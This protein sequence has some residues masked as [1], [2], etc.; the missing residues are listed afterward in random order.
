MN[1][2]NKGLNSEIEP[3]S[4]EQDSF[5]C[6]REIEGESKCKTQ[7]EHCIDYYKDIDEDNF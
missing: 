5:H 6:Q 7:C 4:D 1:E 3:I 2:Q